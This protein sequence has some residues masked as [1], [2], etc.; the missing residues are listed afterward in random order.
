MFT[1]SESGSQ[2][3]ERLEEELLETMRTSTPIMAPAFITKLK[4]TRI[5]RGHQAIFECVVPDTK[6]VCCKWLHDG[7][8]IELIAR[9]RVQ[10]QTIEGFT[11]SELVIDAVEPEDAGKYTVIVENEAGRAQC[12]AELTVVG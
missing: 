9:I 1:E 2:V 7:M 11:T 3:E 10:V 12:E 5:Q 4:D 6:G 8:E